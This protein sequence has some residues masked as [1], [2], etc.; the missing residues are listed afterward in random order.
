MTL[1]KSL[2]QLQAQIGQETLVSDWFLVDQQRIDGFAAATLDH[3]WIH[4]DT[5]RAATD[6]P[7]GGT[8][9]HGFLTL[10]LLP[11]LLGTVRAETPAYPGVTLTVNYGLNRVRFPHPVL[12]GAEIRARAVL[13]SAD[14]VAEDAL[15][16][17]RM[18]T[19]EIRGVEK[20]GCVAET[21]SR[22]YFGRV[23]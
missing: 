20:P 5:E 15:Q 12:A 2:E 10:S 18:V 6:S 11:H 23:S 7:F 13:L 1:E 22:L 3:Q 8:V 4:V 19:V 9:V 17:V 21:V 16:L 14:R